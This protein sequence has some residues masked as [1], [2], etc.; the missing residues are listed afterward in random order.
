M[1][2]TIGSVMA[3]LLVTILPW[4]GITIGSDQITTT[5]Q[6]IVVVATGLLIWYQRYAKGDVNVVGG[7]K[8]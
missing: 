8:G 3:Q 6:T 2:T 5:I 7:R 1:S 4:L